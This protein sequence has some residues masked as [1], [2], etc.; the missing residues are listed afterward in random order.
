M[1][2]KLAVVL[3]AIFTYSSYAQEGTSS[4]YSFYGIGSLK[5]KGT[6]ENRSMG[7]LSIYTDSIHMNLRNPASY[8]GQNLSSL[9]GE[10]RPVKFTVGGGYSGLNLKT[11]ASEGATSTTTFDYLAVGIPVG[12][13]GFG[14]GLLPYTSVGYNIESGEPTMPVNRYNGNG[15][16]NKAFFA[17]GYQLNKNFSVGVDANYNFGNIQNN[18]IEFVYTGEG[19][20]VQYQTKEENRSDLSGL[21]YNF[22]LTYKGKL[23]DKLELTSGFTYSPKSDLNSLNDRV[24]ST[25]IINTATGSDVVVNSIEESLVEQGLDE[26]NQVLPSKLSF[27]LGIGVPKKWFMGAE[28][29]S[30]KTSEFSN[31]IFNIENAS[32]EDANTFALGGFYIPKYNSLSS[33][34]SRAVYRAGVRFENTG[35]NINTESINEFGISFGVGL[36][37]GQ[38]FSNANIGFE[39]GKRGTTNQN[40][41]QENFFNVNI[42]LSLNDIWFVKKKYD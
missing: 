36:P 34:W 37:V 15:G 23:T 28:Y 12:K 19:E 24:I 7:G 22:G 14:L 2:K 16:L 30:Q 21:N 32:F 6:A 31:R 40:L 8:G 13:L 27:G 5:F 4:P 33:Y 41:I 9:G 26:T 35:L 17:I 20:L 10:N 11:D 39:I 3:I 42:S 18:A 29:T 25:V 38:V 1:I